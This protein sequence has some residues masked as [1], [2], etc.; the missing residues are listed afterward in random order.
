MAP[1]VGTE[2]EVLR[3]GK[4]TRVNPDGSFNVKLNEG[5]GAPHKVRP[6]KMQTGPPP[7]PPKSIVEIFDPPKECE[8]EKTPVIQELNIKSP[9]ST[10]KIIGWG[11]LITIGGLIGAGF[12]HGVG[13]K[14]F[15]AVWK[16]VLGG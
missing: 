3:R 12:L 10:A 16:Y 9:R 8:P 2:I 14:I 1:P 6:N 13:H 11:T 5:R 7:F 4:L 15:N